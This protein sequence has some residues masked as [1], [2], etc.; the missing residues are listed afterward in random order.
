MRWWWRLRIW[1]WLAACG[2]NF[3]RWD[4]SGY[5]LHLVA[6]PANQPNH[7]TGGHYGQVLAARSAGSRQVNAAK[8]N[9]CPT[10]PELLA[11]SVLTKTK[12]HSASNH[13]PTLCW[14]RLMGA[15]L[16]RRKQS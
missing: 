5:Q 11:V 14:R 10:A 15:C 1:V 2:R 4:G 13:P 9:Y 6:G 8:H 3:L 16:N 7:F 12:E